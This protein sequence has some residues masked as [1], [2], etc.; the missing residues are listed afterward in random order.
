MF[1]DV[2]LEKT[3]KLLSNK[4]FNLPVIFFLMFTISVYPTNQPTNQPELHDLV[5]V[6]LFLLFSVAFLKFFSGEGN[7]R[8]IPAA[9]FPKVEQ[10]L[11]HLGVLQCIMG[12]VVF[13]QEVVDQKLLRILAQTRIEVLA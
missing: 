11:Q 7:V 12:I 10:L 4:K 8:N 3:F 1:E 13:F 9:G 5:V 2:K 6:A